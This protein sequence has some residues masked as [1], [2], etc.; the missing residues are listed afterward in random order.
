M[1]PVKI[2]YSYAHEDKTL[3][4]ELGKHL[5]SLL[6]NG[7][8]QDWYD[9]QIRPGNVWDDAIKEKLSTADFILLLISADFL[10]S[11][12]IRSTELQIAMERQAKNEA[13]VV[14][15]VLRKCKYDREW[16]GKLQA[17]PT[18]GLPVAS[19]PDQ[20]DAW[21]DVVNWLE[22]EFE[23]FREPPPAD[24]IRA[25]VETANGSATN[26]T[27]PASSP[28]NPMEEENRELATK[29]TEGVQGLGE[30]MANPRVRDFVTQE[31]PHLS[32]IDQALQTLID[33]KNVH[34]LLH[35][36]QFQCYNFV[37]E[38]SRQIESEIEWP[39]LVR[40]QSDLKV[41]VEALSQAEKAL[42]E[43]EFSWLDNLRQAQ[44]RLDEAC[45]QF[46][47]MPLQKAARLMCEILQK[48][49][50]L[51]DAKLCAAAR[52]LPLD[53]LRQALESIEGKL[54]AKTLAGS[55]GRQFCLG[56]GALPQLS[57]NLQA[58]TLEHT[59]WQIIAAQFWT[60]D[61]LIAE[62][63]KDL[64]A[65]PKPDRPPIEEQVE[66]VRTNWRRLR[67]RLET[68]CAGGYERVCD[69]DPCGH[70]QARPVA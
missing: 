51:F 14:P 26:E 45:D 4:G 8:C 25:P 13:R 70:K 49:P 18:E 55:A 63:G 41:I 36:L 59:R 61:V 24:G 34:D 15:I 16:F 48:W 6:Y 19:W 52:T 69:Q 53:N 42:P 62:M 7:V 9:G 40:P 66:E 3:R 20:D 68:I 46:T 29:S 44:A 50:A 38:Q 58:L 22:G 43:E 65:P 57:T 27:A 47:I 2:F 60:I 21:T 32:D 5:S 17:I 12:Y 35:D 23:K 28:T 1:E 64:S 30:L 56:L 33:Y 10:A 11:K 39:Q 67:P 37:F 54:S 31:R